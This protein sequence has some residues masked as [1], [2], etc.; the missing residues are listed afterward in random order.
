MRQCR[1]QQAKDYLQKEHHGISNF[2]K[3]FRYAT[4]KINSHLGFKFNI[5]NQETRNVV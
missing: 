3:Y 2:Q 4:L 1:V 5:R